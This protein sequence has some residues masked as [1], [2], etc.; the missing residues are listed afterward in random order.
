MERNPEGPCDETMSPALT[1]EIAEAVRRACV[2][3]ALEGYER[4][5]VAGLCHEG[6]LECA[7]DAIRLVDVAGLVSAALEAATR[8]PAGR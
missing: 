7:V 1:L 4:A 6:A 5:Q 3:A 2:D 8:A